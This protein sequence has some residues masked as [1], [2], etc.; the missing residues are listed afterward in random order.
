MELNL[1]FFLGYVD[2]EDLTSLKLLATFYHSEIHAEY[3][4]QPVIQI[5]EPVKDILR[6]NCEQKKTNHA[7]WDRT[8]ISSSIIY[9]IQNILTHS[10]RTQ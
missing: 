5:V 4:M 8:F 6:P 7:C 9:L 1:H 2:L 3:Q 10:D